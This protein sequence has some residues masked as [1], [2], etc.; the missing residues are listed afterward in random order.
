MN[1]VRRFLELAGLK[2]K[3]RKKRLPILTGTLARVRRGR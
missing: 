1:P 3:Q 2:P